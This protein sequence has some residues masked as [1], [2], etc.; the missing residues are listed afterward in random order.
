R[1]LEV[2]PVVDRHRRRSVPDRHTGPIRRGGLG[3]RT[4]ALRTVRTQQHDRHDDHHEQHHAG[5]AET[6]HPL[7]LTGPPCLFQP[8]GFGPLA[9]R[10]LL[11]AHRRRTPSAREPASSA[12][13]ATP[14]AS[15]SAS[16]ILRT[17]AEPTT[18]PSAKPAISAAWS[19]FETPR[20][21]LIGRSVVLRVRSTRTAAASPTCSRVPVTPMTDVA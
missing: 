15:S 1:A 18:T 12:T 4:G 6:Q 7:A 5:D 20:P 19:A 2:Q 16:S 9:G 21:T 14:A 8:F 3:H 13:S 17:N 11:G 10:S